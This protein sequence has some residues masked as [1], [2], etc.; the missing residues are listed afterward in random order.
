MIPRGVCLAVFAV[1]VLPL[2]VACASAP[3]C[4]PPPSPVAVEVPPPAPAADAGLA[5]TARGGRDDSPC[6]AKGRPSVPPPPPSETPRPY[7]APFDESDLKSVEQRVRAAMVL[8]DKQSLLVVDWG[9]DEAHG[10]LREMV[11]EDGSGHGGS[12]RV[13][14]FQWQT[15]GRVTVRKIASSH[16]YQ[17]GVTVEQAETSTT[18]LAPIV[19]TSRVAM[20]A[21]PH[22]VRLRSK[23]GSRVLGPS[24]TNDFHLLLRLVDDGGRVTENRYSGYERS[25]EQEHIVPMRL[26]TEPIRKLLEGLAF[27][28]A[29]KTDEDRAFFTARLTR[30]LATKPFWWVKERYVANAAAFGTVDAIPSLVALAGEKG[31]PSAD[32]TRVHAFDALA[33]I[34]GWDPRVDGTAKRSD[35]AAATLAKEA[36]DP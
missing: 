8:H 13:V 23:N 11:L 10:P 34:T 28:P 16:Y 6:F 12:L 20:L 9:C 21:R 7:C 32:R 31:E 2:A 18:Q 15:D 36:C 17:P 33:A 14:R 30:T 5:A 29:T 25:S 1:A 26:A 24:S 27:A 3:K 4:P 35:D 22:V 19:A